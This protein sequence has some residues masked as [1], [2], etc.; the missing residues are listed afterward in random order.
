MILM[1]NQEN[2][3]D[4]LYNTPKT[5][6]VNENPQITQ[7]WSWWG[8]F[9]YLITFVAAGNWGLVVAAI[10]LQLIPFIN[11]LAI[12][13]FFIYG[14]LNGKQMLYNAPRFSNH[15]EKIWAIKT[16]ESIGK[17]FAILLLIAIVI[18]LLF[19]GSML[20]ILS[21]FTSNLSM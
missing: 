7:W 12:I 13:G 8:S 18:S 11:F 10:I 19:A 20:A 5:Y 14:W 17:F 16:M 21:S 3:Q 2:I 4:S 1:S 6:E 9:G 15:D